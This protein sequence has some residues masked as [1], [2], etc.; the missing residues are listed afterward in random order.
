M[1]AYLF[2][3]LL[4]EADIKVIPCAFM[5]ADAA[6]LHEKPE[7]LFVK[8][9]QFLYLM[10]VLPEHARHHFVYRYL[11]CLLPMFHVEHFN[12]GKRKKLSLLFSQHNNIREHICSF[13]HAI[14]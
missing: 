10:A 5:L 4:C 13:K 2:S 8:I 6:Y 9:S 12:S 7:F 1:G 11:F 3:I 14:R